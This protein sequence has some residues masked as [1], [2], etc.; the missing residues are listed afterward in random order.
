MA[1]AWIGN[2]DVLVPHAV[3]HAATLLGESRCPVITID[4]DVDATRAAIALA[5]RMGA[6]YDH[7]NDGLA[8]ETA[9]FTGHGGVFLSPG[10]ALRRA[11]LLLFAGELPESAIPFLE[12]L[13]HSSPDLSG[14]QA[15][16]FFSLGANSLPDTFTADTVSLA[17]EGAGPAGT[18]AALRACQSGRR[19]AVAIE[20]FDRFSSSVA[21]AR[22][23]AVVCSGH[24]CDA[25][26]LEM[27]QGL[28][29][30]LNKVVRASMLLWPASEA[31]WSSALISTWTT[32]FPLRTSYFSGQPSHDPWRWNAVRMIESGEADL[33]LQIEAHNRFAKDGLKVIALTK[34]AQPVDGAAVTIAIGE[35]G[36]DH[37]AVLFSGLTG[38][39]VA[40]SAEARSTFPPAADILRAFVEHLPNDGG[41]PC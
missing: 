5:R 23:V 41:V 6:A 37:D 32:G 11:D 16:T 7:L 31:G 29:S 13:H 8:Q 17:V 36:I 18:V 19:T 15:R 28:V 38:T 33:C 1:V 27:L 26:V 2:R 9:L 20:N 30:E 25:L 21:E 40:R 10:E 4:A 34:A 24:G 39:F 12:K 14:G 35:P 22:F 3:E